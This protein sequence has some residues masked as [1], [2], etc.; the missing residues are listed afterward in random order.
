[1]IKSFSFLSL[2]IS[3][4]LI[5]ISVSL[6]GQWKKNIIDDSL[7]IA[8]SI[9][10]ADLDGD[11]RLDLVVNSYRNGDIFW[12]QNN[13]PSWIK[14]T[15]DDNATAVTFAY[16]GDFDGDDTIDIAA[17][18]YSTDAMV[19]YENN[20]Y[21]WTKHFI[22][23]NADNPDYTIVSDINSDDRPDVITSG[24]A[25]N[26][27]EL[28]WY[29]YQDPA[30]IK[31]VIQPGSIQWGGH[32][33]SDF[34]GDGMPDLAASMVGE[35][36]VVWYKNEGNGL[37]WTRDT[38]DG[39]LPNAWTPVNG[40]MNGDGSSDLVVV[41]GGAYNPGG[42]LV[43]YENQYPAWIK[44]V[45]DPDLPGANWP[46]LTDVNGDERL[47]VVVSVYKERSMVWYEQTDSAWIKH[48]IDNDLREPRQCLIMDMDGDQ[49]GDVLVA[50]ANSFVWYKNPGNTAF[51]SSFE[52]STYS[53]RASDDSLTIGVHMFNPENHPMNVFAVAEGEQ[54]QFIDTVSLFD[55]GAHGDGDPYDH[56]WANIM[57]TEGYPDDVYKV[58]LVAYDSTTGASYD[59]LPEEKFITLGPVSLEDYT[60]TSDQEVFVPGE[61]V[62]IQLTLRNNS[63]N[64]TAANIIAKLVSLDPN[65][66]VS[67]LAGS[68]GDMAAGDVSTS[69]RTF[70]IKISDTSPG[71]TYFPVAVD[72]FH[73]FQKCWRDTFLIYVYEQQPV[74][75]PDTAF[76]YALIDEGVDTNGDS[77]ISFEEAEATIALNVSSYTET[78][79]CNGIISD[80]TGIEAFLNLNTLDCSCNQLTALDVTNNTALKSLICAENNLSEVDVSNNPELISLNVSLND[81]TTLDISMNSQLES[82]FIGDNPDLNEICVW[83]IPFPPTGFELLSEGSPGICF[84][85]ICNSI[86]DITGIGIFGNENLSI[87]P[88]PT[89][90]MLTIE[91]ITADRL[92]LELTSLNGQ[93]IYEKKLEGT[94]HHIDLSSF[95]KGVYFITIR[96]KDFVT[97]R[98]IIKL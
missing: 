67:G 61:M 86:C 25:G 42:E 56:V 75:I 68:F 32:T 92:H 17:C 13:S 40:D 29:E 74:N 47:D 6:S 35:D 80:L 20:H 84:D 63:V 89:Y 21:A 5:G 71:N 8:V 3:A 1:M 66:L 82:L 9:D 10:T 94:T 97:T 58:V 90:T 85:T 2:K 88:N 37:T 65:V 98:K 50:A 44:H 72:I 41:T 46:A 81:L 12:Y 76:L 77:L 83:I 28:V 24:D 14:H 93:I 69:D 62:D 53:I 23:S 51:A 43:W 70:Q 48:I 57:K 38:I 49:S 45:I 4:I 26:G 52:L 30:W 34:D 22:D 79:L 39:D 27:G 11:A 33:V 7:S 91:T 31:H 18:L 96:S 16:C 59:N 87:Y 36:M 95:G 19:W 78:G 54:S 73:E 60:I 55:D 15:V 64:A